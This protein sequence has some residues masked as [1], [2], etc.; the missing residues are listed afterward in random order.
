M[1]RPNVIKDQHDP[2]PTR[3]YKMTYGDY[4][5]EFEDSVVAK[6]YSPDGIHWDLDADDDPLYPR[7][8]ANLLG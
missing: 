8:N 6:A 4:V 3:R 7:H 5:A 1:R 2:D